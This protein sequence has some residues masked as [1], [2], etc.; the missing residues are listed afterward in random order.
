MVGF[1]AV[2]IITENIASPVQQVYCDLIVLQRDQL[3]LW[4]A[5]VNA[6]VRTAV[7]VRS[8]VIFT[9]MDNNTV[10][11]WILMHHTPQATAWGIPGH[12]VAHCTDSYN[13]H[14]E[15]TCSHGLWY[16]ISCRTCD[17]HWYIGKPWWVHAIPLELVLG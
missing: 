15:K 14:V 11:T 3:T 17:H 12:C 2:G 8:A 16:K 10:Y 9:F 5:F 7:E 13:V 1:K 4:D 6:Y